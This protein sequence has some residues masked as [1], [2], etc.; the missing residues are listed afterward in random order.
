M[1]KK[2]IALTLSLL[3]ILSITGCGKKDPLQ[4]LEQSFER[5]MK[6]ETATQKFDMDIEIDFAGNNP[7]FAMIGNM[8]K[9]MN[10]SGIIDINQKTM[11]F[12]GKMKLDLNGMPY[13]MEIYRGEEY[14][15]KSPLSPKYLVIADKDD[16]E[17]MFDEK[18]IKN[19]SKDINKLLFSKLSKENTQAKENIII[20][21][22]NE[23]VEVTPIEVILTEEEAKA[24]FEEM[25]KFILENP[26][27]T[28]QMKKQMKDELK[29]LNDEKTD[30]EI[31]EMYN[32]AMA[33]M[34]N[35]FNGIKEGISLNK[36]DFTYYLDEKNDMRKSDIDYVMVMDISRI[37]EASMSEEDKEEMPEGLDLPII[38]FRITGTSDVFNINKLQEII[39]PEINEE[40]STDLE[41]IMGIPLS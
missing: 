39:I 37:L 10:V 35:V 29:E 8:F 17:E 13:E 36:M 4:R 6:M 41:G 18:F 33:E 1:K 23:K 20:E 21:H 27:F 32:E 19:F 12:A 38:S 11:N 26:E 22:N 3:L 24:I 7:E 31:E 15:I 5:A 2:I 40:N 28:N 34:D 9:D 14:F 16:A 30:K 25:M